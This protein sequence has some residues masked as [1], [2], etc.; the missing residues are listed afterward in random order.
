MT[1]RQ[2]IRALLKL[3][4]SHNLTKQAS[5]GTFQKKVV[6]AEESAK[7][8]PAKGKMPVEKP[9]WQQTPKERAAAASRSF[10]NMYLEPP[11]ALV[12]RAKLLADFG[13]GAKMRA[14]EN[15]YRLQQLLSLYSGGGSNA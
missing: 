11:Q 6:A 3:A 8:A 4:Q 13:L 9:Y 7:K 15:K 14:A 12:N 5:F 2:A 10:A 1:R